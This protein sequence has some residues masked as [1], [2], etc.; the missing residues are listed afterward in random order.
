MNFGK[1]DK[2]IIYYIIPIVFIITENSIFFGTKIL[3]NFYRHM[4]V[5]FIVQSIGKTLSF[6]P[7]VVYKMNNTEVI[8][9]KQ[10][11]TNRLLYKKEYFDKMK[12]IKYIKFFLIM[13]SSLLTYCNNLLYFKL[14]LFINSNLKNNF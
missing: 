6:I 8:I 14:L 7:L 4:F 3:H 12:K 1:I 10:S 5:L 11:F 13:L 2:N 9:K